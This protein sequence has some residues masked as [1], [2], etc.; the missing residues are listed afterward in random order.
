MKKSKKYLKISV[1]AFLI[2][3]MSFISVSAANYAFT[4]FSISASQAWK[5]LSLFK[6]SITTSKGQ[7][8]LSYL[9]P[10]A[11]TF[12][13]RAMKTDQTYESFG[14]STVIDQTGTTYKVAY[15]QN[16]GSGTYIQVQVRNHNWTLTSKKISGNYNVD[17]NW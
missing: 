14:A 1:I 11:V 2:S 6:T 15:N 7:V 16:Y 12:R 5:Q 17:G 9:G 4:D 8:K 3:V 13:A 10:E